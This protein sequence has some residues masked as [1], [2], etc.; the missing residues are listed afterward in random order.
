M[1]LGK[2]EE[3]GEILYAV[4]WALRYPNGQIKT[5]M[6]YTHALNESDARVR[7][8]STLPPILRYSVRIMGAG[9]AVGV[10][11]EETEDKRI[12]LSV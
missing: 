6:H 3:T 12:I 10:W 9:P 5:G 11:A 1:L 8:I 4:A 2:D 7:Y